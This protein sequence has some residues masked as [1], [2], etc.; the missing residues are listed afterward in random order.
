MDWI[1]ISVQMTREVHLTGMWGCVYAT[2]TSLCSLSPWL[3]QWNN[4]FASSFC[5]FDLFAI[6][7]SACFLNEFG[8]EPLNADTTQLFSLDISRKIIS[9]T[10]TLYPI[11]IQACTC[12]N[13]IHTKQT[14]LGA[15]ASKN[16]NI[17]RILRV[18]DCIRRWCSY[19]FLNSRFFNPIDY[20]SDCFNDRIS[21]YWHCL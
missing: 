16:G 4:V 2:P 9:N 12:R 14:K 11:H 17:R 5:L 1:L 18:L 15:K 3:T 19:H 20:C 7:I 21:L 13:P 10:L 6:G 8:L